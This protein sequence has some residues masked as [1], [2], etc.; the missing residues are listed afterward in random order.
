MS[1]STRTNAPKR[2]MI[3]NRSTLAEKL[4][5]GEDS[6]SSFPV[7]VILLGHSLFL[8]ALKMS[9]VAKSST[10]MFLLKQRS[11]DDLLV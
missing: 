10:V 5:S 11:S 7:K 4:V 6:P 2:H 9:P 3:A 8:S 1:V